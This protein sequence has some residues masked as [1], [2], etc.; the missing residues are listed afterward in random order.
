MPTYTAKCKNCGGV[1]TYRR[2]IAERNDT[3]VCCEL[4]MEKMIDAPAGNVDF[5]A[6]GPKKVWGKPAWRKD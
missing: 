5:P 3:P 4:R 6:D 2:S 1:Q